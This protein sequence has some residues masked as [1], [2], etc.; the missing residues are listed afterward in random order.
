MKYR[1]MYSN[2]FRNMHIV[3][4]VLLSIGQGTATAIAKECDLSRQSVNR[5]VKDCW[6]YGYVVC[7]EQ[8]HR[9]N[10]IKRTWRLTDF[11]L[12]NKNVYVKFTVKPVILHDWSKG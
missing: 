2:R 8:E 12:A 10:V 3:C 6:H 4:S 7:E 9:P 11:W 1:K 5:I